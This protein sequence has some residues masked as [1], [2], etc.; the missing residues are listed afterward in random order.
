MISAFLPV[1]GGSRAEYIVKLSVKASYASEAATE[2]Y[3]AYG[4][5]GFSQKSLGGLACP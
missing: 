3:F 4:F 5:V 2:G 1:F